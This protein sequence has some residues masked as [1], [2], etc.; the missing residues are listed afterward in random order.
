MVEYRVHNPDT[1]ERWRVDPEDYL[2]PLQA[3]RM[4]AQP[5]MILE[6]AHIIARD[7]ASRGHASVRVFADVHVAMNDRENSRLVDPDVDLSRVEHGLAP[8]PWLLTRGTQSP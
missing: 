6:T 2:T 1:G 3:E 5:D 7:F 8:K 4:A